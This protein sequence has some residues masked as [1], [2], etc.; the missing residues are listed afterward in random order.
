MIKM[1]NI[2]KLD[3]KFRSWRV[4][5]ASVVGGKNTHNGMKEFRN[6]RV[7]YASVVG[8]KTPTTA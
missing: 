8:G 4:A 5:Y 1:L 6:W 7:A 2:N 3:K